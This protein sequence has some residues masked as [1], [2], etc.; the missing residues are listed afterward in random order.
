VGESLCGFVTQNPMGFQMRVEA[1]AD[2]PDLSE[3]MPIDP[4]RNN[5]RFPQN[6]IE[7]LAPLQDPALKKKFPLHSAPVSTPSPTPPHHTLAPRPR[8]ATLG[9][10]ASPD[11][12]EGAADRMAF[13]STRNL[14]RH[15]RYLISTKIAT[16][17]YFSTG[18]EI[19][20]PKCNQLKGPPRQKNKTV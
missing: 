14:G 13:L 20:H 9:P 11:L 10:I 19:W 12:T 18:H 16:S 1:Y 5:C 2:P 15:L 7:R 17:T 4:T 6:K 3:I 8:L